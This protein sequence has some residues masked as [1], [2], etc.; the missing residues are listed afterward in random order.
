MGLHFLL[1]NKGNSNHFLKINLRGVQSNLHG[2]GARVK[3]TTSTGAFYRQNDGGGGGS[4]ASQSCEPVH[5]GIG[6]ALF[7]AIEVDWPSGLVDNLTSV[8]ANSILTIIEGSVLPA[9][10]AQ[11]IS[12]RLDVMTGAQVGIGGFI[13]TGTSPTKVL[14]RGLGPSL[15]ASGLQGV[16]EDPVLELHEEDGTVNK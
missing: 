14:V 9:A 13:V 3:V 8:P 15:A 10:R 4:Y 11:N 7:A 6:S 5:V 16:L 12:T 2:I 1:K